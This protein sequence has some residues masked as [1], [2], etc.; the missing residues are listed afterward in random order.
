[1]SQPSKKKV[2]VGS[3]SAVA[4]P[5]RQSKRL[6]L[7]TRHDPRPDDDVDGAPMSME[8]RAERIQALKLYL[9]RQKAIEDA[10]GFVALKN[11]L[12]DAEDVL[13]AS[14]AAARGRSPSHVRENFLRLKFSGLLQ[15]CIDYAL[16]IIEERHPNDWVAV[17]YADGILTE[18]I[19]KGAK[20]VSKENLRRCKEF[21]KAYMPDDEFDDIDDSM[22]QR[23]KWYIG[24]F[25]NKESYLKRFTIET[26]KIE[27]QEKLDH[28][29]RF[30]SHDAREGARELWTFLKKNWKKDP[31]DGDEYFREG[32]PLFYEPG[33][34]LRDAWDNDH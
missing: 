14:D 9:E 3:V 28:L 19:L 31:D 26:L 2:K 29:E 7:A 10:E 8:A 34:P 5:L 22:Y 6:Q 13:L 21:A 33:H 30:T 17:N 32:H 16:K 20:E 15:T 1:M 27:I 24:A 23:L 4:G 11:A 12:S 25:R 18:E